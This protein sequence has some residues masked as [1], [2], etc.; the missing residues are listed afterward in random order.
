M[1]TGGVGGGRG[2]GDLGEGGKEGRNV[3]LVVV[4]MVDGRGESCGGDG[5]GG[6][7][8]GGGCEGSGGG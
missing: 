4:V 2:K 7:G 3:W 8:D 1:V 6:G 5:G